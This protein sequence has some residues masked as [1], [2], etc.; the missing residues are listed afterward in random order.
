MITLLIYLIALIAAALVNIFTLELESVQVSFLKKMLK[1]Q[2]SCS[3]SADVA[4]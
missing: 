4:T 1:I 3:S 2:V